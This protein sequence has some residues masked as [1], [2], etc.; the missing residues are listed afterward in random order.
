VLTLWAEILR[1]VPTSTLFIKERPMT[2]AP[3]KEKV[4]ER[5][6]AAGVSRDRVRLVGST[7]GNDAHLAAYEE[8]DVA[9]DPFPY[10]GTT[11]T[12]EALWMG[13]PVVTMVGDRH[14]ARVGASL[15][16]GVGLPDLVA[17]SPAEYVEI[18]VRLAMDTDRRQQLRRTLREQF[19]ASEVGQP[20]TLARALEAEYRRLWA[21][22]CDEE[23]E[24][25]A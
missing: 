6:A 10:N 11:T 22:Y 23:D 7:L 18:A 14:S 3:A 4:L 9:L 12:C 13:V 19:L 2:W 16:N 25:R 8:L 21:R 1:R 5:L 15:L 24:S 20:L 17:R